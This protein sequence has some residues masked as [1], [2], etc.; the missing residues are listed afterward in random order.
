M[1]FTYLGSKKLTNINLFKNN[2]LDRFIRRD[3]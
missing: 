1:Q 3:E 2:N